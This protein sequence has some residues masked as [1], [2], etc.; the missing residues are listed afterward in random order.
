MSV[1]EDINGKVSAKRKW[2]GRFFTLGYW[3]FIFC[4]LLWAASLVLKET[5]EFDVPAAIVDMWKW[6]MGFGSI[7]I[8]GTVAE[9]LLKKNK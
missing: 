6:M 3:T 9:G 5:I 2:A 7:V 4:V 8:L 1:H